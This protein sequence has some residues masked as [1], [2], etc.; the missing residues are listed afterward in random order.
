MDTAKNAI[1]E[2]CNEETTKDIRKAW[3]EEVEC[4]KERESKK[5]T[6]SLLLA[7]TANVAAYG[8]TLMFHKDG[9]PMFPFAIAIIA[10]DLVFLYF[11]WAALM[12]H[13]FLSSIENLLDSGNARFFTRTCGE[14]THIVIKASQYPY[15]I[16]VDITDILDEDENENKTGV[17]DK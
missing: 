3:H 11:Y 1:F 4:Q 5:M 16:G 13:K 14:E 8:A 15:T 10:I 6:A 12:K 2:P 7:L 9:Q 17:E